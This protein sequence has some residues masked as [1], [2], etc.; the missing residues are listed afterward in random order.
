MKNGSGVLHA[1]VYGDKGEEKLVSLTEAFAKIGDASSKLGDILA[2]ARDG[3]GMLHSLAYSDSSKDFDELIRKLHETADNL[4][5]ASS[6]LSQGTG[7]LGALLIDSKVYDNLV[8]VTDDAK[9][10]VIL[11]GLIRSSL[12][13]G[14]SANDGG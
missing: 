9:R 13:H 4:N 8:E 10:S 1:L 3:K 14:Q 5:K 6:S 12:A 11:R 7:T 2:Q